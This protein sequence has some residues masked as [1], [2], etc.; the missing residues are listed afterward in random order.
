MVGKIEAEEEG[1]ENPDS[2]VSMEGEVG[3]TS[4]NWLPAT[5]CWNLG[6]TWLYSLQVFTLFPEDR[7]D[8][9]ARMDKR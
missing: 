1:E 5:T 2:V 8:Y 3:R 4:F 6:H 7:V 9:A